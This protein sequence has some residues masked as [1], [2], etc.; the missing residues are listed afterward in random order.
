MSENKIVE[1]FYKHYIKKNAT[2]LYEMSVKKI[3]QTFCFQQ[4]KEPNF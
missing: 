2:K 1:I 4:L 3:L